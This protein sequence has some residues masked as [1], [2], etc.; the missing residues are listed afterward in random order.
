MDTRDLNEL[1]RGCLDGEPLSWSRFVDRYSPLVTWAIKRKFFKY[2]CGHLISH[3]D[4]VHQKVFAS[5]WQKRSLENVRGRRD[6]SP[7]IIV[8][9]SN[10][11]VDFLRKIK[12]EREKST[13]ED[14][15]AYDSGKTGERFG[16][17]IFARLEEALDGLKERERVCLRMYY[18]KGASHRD[19]AYAMKIPVNS[20]STIIARA[21]NKIRKSIE[22]GK[23]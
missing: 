11:A 19:I 22:R 15:K 2:D 16:E 17:E 12:R 18:E 4:D 13:Y 23:T 1:I 8:L 20:V 7:W 3:I 6:L 9:S 5:I 21:K 14:S 10:A